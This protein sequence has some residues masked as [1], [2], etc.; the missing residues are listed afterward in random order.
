MSKITFPHG[1]DPIRISHDGRSEGRVFLAYEEMPMVVEA[2][3]DEFIEMVRRL[4]PT[5]GRT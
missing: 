5:F 1:P 3:L 4:Y 2:S